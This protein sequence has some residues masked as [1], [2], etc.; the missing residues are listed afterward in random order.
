MSRVSEPVSP[1]ES[2]AVHV[3]V[4]VPSGPI[5]PE[6][7]V[8][9]GDKVPSSR[10][11]ADAVYEIGPPLGPV[12]STVVG[13]VIDTVGAV[14]GAASTTTSK[15]ASPVLSCESVAEQVTVV[16]PRAKLD[17]EAGE[18]LA[19][20]FPSTMSLAVA[21]PNVTDSL[22]SGGV[23][24]TGGGAEGGVTVGGV[25]STADCVRE[26]CASSGA[27]PTTHVTVTEPSTGI[28]VPTG[29]SQVGSTELPSASVPVAV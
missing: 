20:I 21:V 3:T 14:F 1:P 29:E 23:S 15:I 24:V 5:T 12:A 10:S 19:E 16:E 7:G 6:A 28:G 22:P 17:P 11:D 4:V 8:Q 9:L 25:V 26:S 18:Q 2:V 13:P 27:V